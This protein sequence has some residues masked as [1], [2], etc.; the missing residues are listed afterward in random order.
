M[1]DL[2]PLSESTDFSLV[3][4]GP[5]YQLLRRAHVEGDHLELLA[6][7]IVAITSLAW[8]PL[9]LLSSLGPHAAS[10][11]LLSFLG[12]VEVHAR[13]LVAVP[14]LIAAELVVHERLA[15]V[16]R[17][18]VE[19]RIVLPEQLPVL[20][21][22]VDSAMNLRN[23]TTAEVVL[24]V[25]VYTLGLWLWHG[26]VPIDTATWYA[27]PGGRWSLTPAGVWYV[28]VSIPIAQ[29][30]LLRWYWRFFIWFRF[31]WRVSRIDLNLI[32]T[33]PDR[34]AGLGFLGKG[35]YAFAPILFAQGAML[36][37]VVASRVLYRGESLLS[38]KLQIGGFVAFFVVAV[39]VP[40]AMFA[41]R[42][43]AARRKG[44]ADYG[45]LAERYID[46]FHRK[47][48]LGDAARSDDLLGTGDIQ[49]LADLGNSYG[50]VRDMRVVPFGLD[51]IVRLAAVT[52]APFLPLLLTIWSP[53]E[54]IMRIVNIVF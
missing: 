12:D 53:E 31:L 11:G 35:T 25:S 47:W 9:A 16:V 13:F 30:I 32:P 19:R 34:C 17:R 10:P 28:F 49:S 18:F 27:R 44:W 43:A 4:G 51:D 1:T 7:R 15:P 36:A 52:A 29:F 14:I 33:H 37:G 54:L 3:L 39:L 50:F 24:L 26:R 38:F 20:Q 41:A 23:S 45:L 48:V 2:N 8:V 5:L 40:L 46:A 21:R 42:L 6:R 22:V